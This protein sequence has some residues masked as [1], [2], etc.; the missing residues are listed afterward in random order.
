MPAVR[1][2]PWKTVI[3]VA[4]VV[5]ECL[6]EDLSAKDRR[7]L[8]ELLRRSKGDPRSLTPGERQEMLAI[9]RQVDLRK[10]GTRVSGQVA[11]SRSGRLLGR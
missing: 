11:M 6:G 10:L 7:R 2:V 1:A 4:R 9:V 8:T 5:V 3:N